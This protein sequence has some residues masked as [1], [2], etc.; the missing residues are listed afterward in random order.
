MEK[1]TSLMSKYVLYDVTDDTVQVYLDGS[2][3]VLYDTIE[4]AHKAWVGYPEQPI[5]VTDLPKR[6]REQIIAENN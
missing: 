4:D 3:A 1:L 5:M 6:H 2:K